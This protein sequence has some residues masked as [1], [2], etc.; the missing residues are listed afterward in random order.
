MILGVG[1]AESNMCPD[2]Q[3][4][5]MAQVH[6]CSITWIILLPLSKSNKVME[7]TKLGMGPISAVLEL[8]GMFG[9]LKTQ[10]QSKGASCSFQSSYLKPQRDLSYQMTDQHGFWIWPTVSQIV[11][12]PRVS[13]P[14][15]HQALFCTGQPHKGWDQRVSPKFSLSSNYPGGIWMSG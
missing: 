2:S 9:H 3:C 10:S 14:E 1:A 7:A 8:W 6:W 13:I 15:L 4:T 12:W 5:S 11:C